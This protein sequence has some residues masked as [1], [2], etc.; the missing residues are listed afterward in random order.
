MDD[1]EV[2]LTDLD[3]VIPP[4]VQA[5][6]DHLRQSPALATDVEFGSDRQKSLRHRDTLVKRQWNGTC[7][8]FATIAAME[9]C[10]G[11]RFDMS[12][13][14]MW[15]FYGKYSTQMAVDA[16]Q[17]HWILDE[18]DWPQNQP[19]PTNYTPSKGR[20]RIR[21]VKNLETNWLG[22]LQAL[23]EDHPCIVAMQT[24]KKLL[25]GATQVEE[26]TGFVRRGG[27]A[28]CVS[29]YKVEGGRGYFLVKNSWGLSTGDGGYQWVAFRLFKSAG[30]AIF[31]SVLEVEDRYPDRALRLGDVVRVEGVDGEFKVDF[32]NGR[33]ALHDVEAIK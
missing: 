7:S 5:R 15:D 4:E 6:I 23:D 19:H 10:L 1:F 28:L 27:H 8:T 16:A 2:A 21:R 24:P 30:Y 14:S 11:G 22:V 17:S 25:A 33:I 18:R 3:Q 31:W 26:G 20:F 29:G 12:E 32:E 9:N 13:R